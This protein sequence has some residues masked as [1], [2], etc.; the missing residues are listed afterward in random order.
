MDRGGTR[1]QQPLQRLYRPRWLLSCDNFLDTQSSCLSCNKVSHTDVAAAATRAPS[2]KLLGTGVDQELG[3]PPLHANQSTAASM[4]PVSHVRGSSAMIFKMSPSHD[5][6]T[7][8]NNPHVA[9]AKGVESVRP[10]DVDSP[11]PPL[12]SDC[13][14]QPC[15]CCGS[16]FRVDRLHNVVPCRLL[17]SSCLSV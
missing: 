4:Q 14:G 3:H 1:L 15:S 2:V 8:R 11:I 10:C 7:Q 6:C 9:V 13:Q 16:T 5:H 12:M 17:K